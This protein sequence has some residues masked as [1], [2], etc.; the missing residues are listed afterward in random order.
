[1]AGIEDIRIG[2]QDGGDLSNIF[3]QD[4]LILLKE[5]KYDP[6]EVATLRDK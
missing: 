4:D 3:T 5:F 6:Y 1:M 2:Y